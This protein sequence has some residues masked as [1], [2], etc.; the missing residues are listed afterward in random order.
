M[1]FDTRLGLYED[2]PPQDA[3]KFIDAVQNFFELTQKLLLSIPSRMV[4]PYIDTPTLKKFFKVSD[5]IFEIGQGFLDK[6]MRELKEMA[7]KEIEPS[8]D[9]QGN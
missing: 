4:R 6:K 8:G 2:P 9:T 1:A 3:L 7:E 5:D